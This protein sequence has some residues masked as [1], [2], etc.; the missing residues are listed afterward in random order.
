[1]TFIKLSA[2]IFYRRLVKETFSKRFL[3]ITW[4]A[5]FALVASTI[6]LF[7]AFITTCDPMDAYWKQVYP[8]YK[9]LTKFTCRS[10]ESLL[11]INEIS[12]GFNIISDIY[13]IVIPTL[14]VT[15]SRLTNRQ[16]IAV[17]LL[18][19]VGSM[20]VAPFSVDDP[21]D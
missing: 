13:S 16:R 9:K 3:Y 2:L 6:I 12:T 14:L 18:L 17:M 5:I 8:D 1:M 20:Y 10:Q 4:V 21:E 19:G 11:V 15:K 7:F